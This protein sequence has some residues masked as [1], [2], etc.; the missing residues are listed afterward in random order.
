MREQART[1]RSGFTLVEAVATM[2]ILAVVS[3]SASRIIFAAAD[4]YA[5][6]AVRAELTSE[7]STAMERIMT[8]LRSIPDRD[9]A[10]GTPW[11]DSASV[12]GISFGGDS[13]LELSGSQLE[14]TVDGETTRTLVNNVTTL[15]LACFDEANQPLTLPLTGAGCDGIRR[16]EVSITRTR[17]GVAET[18]RS[19]VYLRCAIVGGGS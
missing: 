17:H 8:E 11:I 7:L 5:G 19:R 1:S 4:A 2:S 9:A 10:P 16:V 14:L 12:S 3:L 18:L 15:S 13:E 6:E